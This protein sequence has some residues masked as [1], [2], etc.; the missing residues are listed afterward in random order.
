MIELE[1]KKKQ[2]IYK[3][4]GPRNLYLTLWLIF[5]QPI[6]PMIQVVDFT[7][8]NLFF[9]KIKNTKIDLL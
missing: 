5:S 1:E 7:E 4:K 2:N 9:Y 3:K 8:L 6:R